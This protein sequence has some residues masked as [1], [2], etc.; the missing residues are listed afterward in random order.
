MHFCNCFAQ[1]EQLHIAHFTNHHFW[2]FTEWVEGAAFVFKS[3]WSARRW[4]WLSIFIHEF[5]NTEVCCLFHNCMCQSRHSGVN[6]YFLALRW[7]NR[8]IVHFQQVSPCLFDLRLRFRLRLCLDLNIQQTLAH[9]CQQVSCSY[10]GAFAVKQDTFV[11]FLSTR[12]GWL[13]TLSKSPCS[14]HWIFGLWL[15]LLGVFTTPATSEP[16]SFIQLSLKEIFGGGRGD[17]Y[18]FSYMTSPDPIMKA[19]EIQ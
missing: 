3:A 11:G 17:A 14:N 1:L 12:T 13:L 8:W 18:T 15:G 5:A 16:N 2:F 9:N 7:T 6:V 10:I 19:F 4:G